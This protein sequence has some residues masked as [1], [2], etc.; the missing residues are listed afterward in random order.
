METV[1]GNFLNGILHVIKDF[2]EVIDLSMIISGTLTILII[3]WW[4]FLNG[5]TFEILHLKEYILLIHIIVAYCFG[6]TA[7]S[8]GRL[9]RRR[10]FGIIGN[11]TDIPYYNQK[12]DDHKLNNDAN[13]KVYKSLGDSS[14]ES[15]REFLW[16]ELRQNKNYGYSKTF[17]N[18]YWAMSVIFDSLA[19]FLLFFF[20]VIIDLFFGIYSAYIICDNQPYQLKYIVFLII[21]IF[22][23]CFMKMAAI[24]DDYQ[25]DEL[26]ASYAALVRSR[27][28]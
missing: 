15:L 13:I 21:I 28:T 20:I 18:K 2:F 12:I 16:S 17:L 6:L 10:V 22:I 24:Y 3:Y 7:F 14:R 19:G 4:Q 5:F 8:L 9:I 25:D 27:D 23:F 1:I 11:R 26:L